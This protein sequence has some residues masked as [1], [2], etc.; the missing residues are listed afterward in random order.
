MYNP[1]P[2]VKEV[3]IEEEKKDTTKICPLC[4]HIIPE[5]TKVCPY[6]KKKFD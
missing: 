1:E 4:G 3:K 5:S 2:I 6:C